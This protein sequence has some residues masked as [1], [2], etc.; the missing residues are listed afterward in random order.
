MAM[1]GTHTRLSKLRSAPPPGLAVK[2]CGC[3]GATRESEGKKQLESHELPAGRPRLIDF[4]V[5][6]GS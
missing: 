4:G 2:E 3:V 1:L 6:A 5:F